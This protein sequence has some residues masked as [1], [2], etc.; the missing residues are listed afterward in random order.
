MGEFESLLRTSIGL[1]VASIGASA[2]ARAIRDR[3]RACRLGDTGQYW[4]LVRESDTELQELVDLIVVPETWFFRDRQAFDMLARVAREE[5]LPAR[6]TGLLQ[7]LSMPSS[8]GE[9]P[10][11]MAMALLDAGVPA[12]RFRVDAVDVSARAL[13]VATRGVYGKNSFRGTDLGYRKQYFDE[14]DAGYQLHEAVRRQVQVRRGNI[15]AED[16]LPGSAIYDAI[17]CRNLLIYLDR[18]TQERAIRAFERLLRPEG[19]LF[20]APSETSMMLSRPAEWTRETR[21]FGFRRGGTPSRIVTPRRVTPVSTPGAPVPAGPRRGTRL[22]FVGPTA[23]SSPGLAEQTR[24][25]P[26]EPVRQSAVPATSLDQATRLADLGRFAEAA[27]C[28][29]DHL[30][31]HGPSAEVFHLLGVLRDAAG[32]PTEAVTYYR[33]ALYLEPHNQ[34]VLIHLALLLEKLGKTAEAQV[35]R[36]RERRVEKERHDLKANRGGEG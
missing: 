14:T 8:T 26:A 15:C 25:G 11:S 28:C 4:D 6:P 34:D 19:L 23:T 33:K 36:R 27:A 3:Q 32:D 20:V 2:V 1:D 12:S 16:F 18:G 13:A 10:Y 7:M 31:R 5:W 21:A 17:F 22:A 29:Q 24:Q 9:E 35:V 30:A